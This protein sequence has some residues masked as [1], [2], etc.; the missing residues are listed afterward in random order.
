VSADKIDAITNVLQ[1][2]SL[3]S[4]QEICQI[5]MAHTKS[6]IPKDI[7]MTRMMLGGSIPGLAVLDTDIDFYVMPQVLRDWVKLN[8]KYFL[9]T[10]IPFKLV[11]RGLLLD[12]PP[13]VGKSMAARAL[14]KHWE[15]PC[16]GSTLPQR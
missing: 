11:P 6:L 12:G 15:V 10:T 14:A 8:D 2:L 4:A 13:G 3:K 1:G 5:T 7:R 9:S 16:S